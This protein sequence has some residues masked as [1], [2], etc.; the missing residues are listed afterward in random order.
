MSTDAPPRRPIEVIARDGPLWVIAKPAGVRV[1]PAGDDGADDLIAGMARAG[2]PAGM[3][4]IHRLDAPVSGAVLCSADPAVRAEVGRW[5][6][7]RQI[8]KVYRAVVF[9]RT[10]RKGIIRR[11]LAVGRGRRQPA[12]T[13]YRCLAVHGRFSYLEVRPETGRKHQ[14]RRHLHGIGHPLVGD[15]RYT[16]RRFTPV[17]AFPGRIWLHAWRLELPDGRAFEAPLP[18][19]LAEHLEALAAGARRVDSPPAE[20]AA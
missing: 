13:R 12:V 10:R 5:F 6:A 1:H 16:P 18:A 8:G 2:L 3:S 14:I 15:T 11:S 20:P 9:G 4:P 19:D 17:P 7:E